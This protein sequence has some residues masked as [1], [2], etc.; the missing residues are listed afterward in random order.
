MG[1]F[2]AKK[3]KPTVHVAS[4]NKSNELLFTFMFLGNYGAGKTSILSTFMNKPT[5]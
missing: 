3:A 1:N 5:V 2:G 4:N